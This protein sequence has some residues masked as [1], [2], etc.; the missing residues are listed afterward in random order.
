MGKNADEADAEEIIEIANKASFADQQMQVKENVHSQ[1][2]AFC[3]YMDEMLLPN[4]KRVNDPMELS[5]QENSSPHHSGLNSAKG[6]CDPPNNIPG[7]FGF[8]LSSPYFSCHSARFYPLLSYLP[9]L[10]D[11]WC[12]RK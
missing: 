1:I 4:E 9:F 11:P 2:K 10:F 12:H 6:R 8:V 3:T 5:Q 7:D